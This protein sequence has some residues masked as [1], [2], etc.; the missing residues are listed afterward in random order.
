MIA[1]NLNV[2]HLDDDYLPLTTFLSARCDETGRES[3][4]ERT[5][6]GTRV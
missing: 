4:D 5:D 2:D 6:D 1:G 3:E